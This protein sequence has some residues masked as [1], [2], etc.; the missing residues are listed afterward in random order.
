LTEEYALEV[1]ESKHRLYE[2]DE[3]EL[4]VAGAR[5]RYAVGGPRAPAALPASP[6]PVVLVHGLGGTIENW[7]GIAP[8]LARKHR[9][10][11]PDLP[12]HGRSEPLPG[13]IRHLDP[14]A[15]AVVSLLDAEGID[16][17]V[18]VGHSLGGVVA[19]RAAVRRP[20]T[21]RGIILAGAAGTGSRSRAARV[22]LTVDGFIRP[23]RAIAPH[24]ERWARSALGRR[25]AFWWGVGDTRALEP[26]FAEAFFVGPARHTSTLQACRALL[27]TDPRDEL[28]HVACPVLCLWGARDHWVKLDDGFEYARRLGAPVRTIAGCAHLLIGERPEVCL[29]AIEEFVSSV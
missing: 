11:V 21:V 28:P 12:G 29:A 10:I 2:F 19:L 14:Y 20:E 3:R 23:G 27:A 8:E 1:T 13:K 5:L 17:A 18:W 24:R 26:E 7:R 9:V 6:P 4:V 15:D 16:G 22:T 25:V